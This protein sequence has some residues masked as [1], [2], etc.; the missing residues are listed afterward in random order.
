MVLNINL[1]LYSLYFGKVKTKAKDVFSLKI[2]DLNVFVYNLSAV[3][4][5]AYNKGSR[6]NGLKHN[7]LLLNIT[8]SC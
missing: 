8:L 7:A 4:A 2:V 5:E 1:S 6:I 3:Y